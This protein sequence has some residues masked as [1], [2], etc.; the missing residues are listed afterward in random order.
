MHILK[1]FKFALEGIKEAFK[2]EKNM[3]VHF[4]IA[5][6]VLILAFVLKFSWVELAILT[7]TIGLVLALELVN[8]SLEEIVN[9]VS[10]QIQEKAKVAKDVAAAAVLISAIVA[11][12]VACFLYL[13]KIF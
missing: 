5:T 9:I 2:T 12:L 1:S 11:I 13:A 7:L 10:P 3:R 8:T 6:I 4:I